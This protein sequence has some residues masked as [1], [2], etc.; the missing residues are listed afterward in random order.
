MHTTAAT[1]EGTLDEAEAARLASA[2]A[3]VDVDATGYVAAESL[4]F[5]ALK[6]AVPPYLHA[7]Q[8]TVVHAW[9]PASGVWDVAVHREADDETGFTMVGTVRRDGELVMEQVARMRTTTGSRPAGARREAPAPPV[10]R[11][12]RTWRPT[13][14]E[15]VAYSGWG[16][17]NVHTDD[18]FARSIG[19][20]GV[21]VQGLMVQNRLLGELGV[22][23]STP[24]LVVDT[25]FTAIVP[26]GVDV[27]LVVPVTEAEQPRAVAVCGGKVAVTVAV[28]TQPAASA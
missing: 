27:E 12:S 21:V 5:R 8:R 25:R 22:G 3:L 18:A 14:D 11:T 19:L 4:M 23:G 20:P 16:H 17:P 1:L 24:P 28:S 13:E 6:G 9:R 10:A 7:S 2:V 15:V 26:V